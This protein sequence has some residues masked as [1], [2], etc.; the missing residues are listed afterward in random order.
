MAEAGTLST[1][2]MTTDLGEATDDH[3]IGRTITWITGVLAGQSSDI[4]DYTGTGGK[5]KYTLVTDAPSAADE[6]ILY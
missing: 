5:L 6:F 3:Y 1:T 4:T 2:E